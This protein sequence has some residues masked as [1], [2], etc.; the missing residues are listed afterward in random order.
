MYSMRFN[1]CFVLILTFGAACH[2]G[3]PPIQGATFTVGT[4]LAPVAEPGVEDAIRDALSS[5]LVAQGGTGEGSAQPIN[6]T[7]LSA[8]TAP[9][10]VGAT[11]QIHTATLRVI[12][13]SG[14]RE[15]RLSGQRQY[16]VVGP[17][18]ADA[19]RSEAFKALALMVA[20]DAVQWMRYAPMEG[21]H[22]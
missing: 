2:L 22:E 5:A 4:I 10:A 21:N 11:Q 6:V 19:A 12:V 16:P 9:T 1:V 18:Q 8:N 15:T 17:N 7:V 14:G 3:R 20:A 13:Q